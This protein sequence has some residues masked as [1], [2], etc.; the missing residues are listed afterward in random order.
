MKRTIIV[1]IFF[2]FNIINTINGQI[3]SCYK[4]KPYLLS[5]KLVQN[6]STSRDSTKRIFTPCTM[7]NGDTIPSFLLKEI[8]IKHPFKSK[9]QMQR[10]YKRMNRLEYYVKKVYPYALL[11]S[12]KI[13]EINLKLENIK[14]KKS[15]RKIIKYEY[16][17][18]MHEFKK[19]LS[20]LSIAQGRILIRL[21]YRETNNSAFYHIQDFKGKFTAYFWQTIARLFGNNL[22]STYD[23]YGKD[24]DIE[25]FVLK[26]QKSQEDIRYNKIQTYKAI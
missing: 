3:T 17:K 9:K 24:Y 8:I 1:I 2:I 20:K 19:P 4:F 7:E 25:H 26:L 5:N 12:S 22:K 14:N 13:N 10:Y 15:R 16:S 23:P 6:K 18:L 21:I 11:A